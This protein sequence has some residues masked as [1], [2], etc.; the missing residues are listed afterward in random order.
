[1]RGKSYSNSNYTHKEDFQG[2]ET[3]VMKKRLNILLVFALVLSMLTPAFAFAAEGEDLGVYADAV[4]RLG[5]LGVIT[6]HGDGSFAPEDSITRAEATALMVRLL[7]LE[8]AAKANMGTTQF[9]DGVAPWAS[10]YVNVAV[11]QGIIQGYADGTFGEKDPVTHA[12]ILAMLVRALGYEPAVSEGNWPTNYIVQASQLEITDGVEVSAYAP[13]KRGEVALF[14]DNSLVVPKLVQYGFGD[15]KLYAVSG[16][17][18]SGVTEK[19]IL[20]DNLGAETHSGVLSDSFVLLGSNLDENEIVVDGEVLTFTGEVNVLDL[21]A[22]TGLKV[23]AYT[24]ASNKVLSWTVTNAGSLKG[25]TVE[26]TAVDEIKI[27]TDT[28]DFA[29]DAS[30]VVN[31]GQNVTADVYGN[32]EEFTANVIFNKDDE[33]TFLYA[34]N[35]YNTASII[36]EVDALDQEVEMAVGSDLDLEDTNYVIVKDGV[37]IGINDLE[38]ND[39]VYVFNSGDDYVIEVA[40]SVSGEFTKVNGAKTKLTIGGETYNAYQGDVA[41]VYFNNSTGAYSSLLGEEVTAYIGLD[42]TVVSLVGEGEAAVTDNSNYI[43]GYEVKTVSGLETKKYLRAYDYKGAKVDYVLNADTNIDV[44]TDV[45]NSYTGSDALITP[46]T[47][48]DVTVSGEKLTKVDSVTTVPTTVGDMTNSRVLLSSGGWKIVKD[49]TVFVTVDGT[50]VDAYT[51]A[52]VQDSN[53]DSGLTVDALYDGSELKVLMITDASF[54]GGVSA[55]QFGLVTSVFE[56]ADG[57]KVT[58]NVDGVESTYEYDPASFTFEANDA[59]QFTVAAGEVDTATVYSTDTGTN[60]TG[61]EEEVDDVDG[62][63][64]TFDPSGYVVAS[65]DVVVY[66]ITGSEVE[67]VSV[68]D[69]RVNDV[70]NYVTVAGEA[71]VIVIVD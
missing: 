63:L 40:T 54:V 44:T 38:Q 27:G 6:G 60:Y 15:N 36:D 35:Y 52:E 31:Y 11:Q 69:I 50:D 39:V 66:D 41:D 25:E 21:L 5:G 59:V 56:D 33:V 3:K 57:D 32:G 22:I 37:E 48:Y 16:T 47:I 18:A 19:T 13:A 10:G 7:G 14:A 9:T 45:Y 28:F 4:T 58:V 30:V 51:W 42:G 55:A 53:L 71:V 24:N 61:F 64:I 43:F 49:S 23:K 29:T 65:S 67:V 70:V 12:Q 68:D 2:G 1:M 26:I 62:D 20:V 34:V 8:A 46:A 17:P